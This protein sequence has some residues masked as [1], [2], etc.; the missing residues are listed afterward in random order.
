MAK[1]SN[2]SPKAK[3]IA[4]L[5]TLV[6]FG[7]YMTRKNF[8]VMLR[9]IAKSF[10]AETDIPVADI[11]RYE[12]ELFEYLTATKD[13]LL[14]SIRETGTLSPEGEAELKEAIIYTKDKFLGKDQ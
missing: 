1:K 9:R 2:I 5:C 6:Y 3:A 12:G 14:K 11:N 10:N 8:D 7:S 4:W 13:E